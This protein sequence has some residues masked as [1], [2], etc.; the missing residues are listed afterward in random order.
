MRNVPLADVD[1]LDRDVLAIGTDYPP[2][3][4][5]AFHEHRRAQFLYG[6]TG[7]MQVD[8]GDGSWTVPTDRAVLIPPRTGHQ[9]VMRGVS[10]RSLYLEP[11]AVP[12][13]PARCRVVAVSP[14]LRELLLAAVDITPEYPARGRDGAVMELIL[15]EIQA[16]TPLPFDLPLPR[17][18]RLRA[19]CKRFQHEPGIHVPLADWA[20]RSHLSERT[21]NRLFP[22]ETG[23]TYQRW[24]QRACVL[25]AITLL[26]TGTPV[27][28][29]AATLGYDT[30]AAFT[31]MF[32]RETG[33]APST[34]RARGPRRS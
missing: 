8:T 32:R 10:T 16:L 28:A 15:H 1:H 9:V 2:G 17:H 24:R 19:L 3:H 18:P 21:L 29:V 7:T 26:A 6:A 27:T 33:M 23:L 11:A 12:W 34:F 4:V 30:P 25:H 14:L 31:A 13:F 22:A 20:A 5:L